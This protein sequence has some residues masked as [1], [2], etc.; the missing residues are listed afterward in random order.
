ME[1]LIKN[2]NKSL[3]DTLN[4]IT[5]TNKSDIERIQ[6][7]NHFEKME[8]RELYFTEYLNQETHKLI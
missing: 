8:V 2:A 3:E 7:H 6:L 5:R 1:S 4:K